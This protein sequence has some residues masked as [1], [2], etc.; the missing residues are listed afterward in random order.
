M[1]VVWVIVCILLLGAIIFGVYNY[2]TESVKEEK[3]MNANK[4]AQILVQ[5][6]NNKWKDM[7]IDLLKQRIDYLEDLLAQNEISF[8]E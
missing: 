7:K 6:M 4:E 1:S 2:V 3:S 8:K 5:K